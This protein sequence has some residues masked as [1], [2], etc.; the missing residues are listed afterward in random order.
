[1]PT[2]I[3]VYDHS[4]LILANFQ[5]TLELAGF[6]VTARFPREIEPPQVAKHQPDFILL[7]LVQE[8]Y[9]SS[10]ERILAIHDEPTLVHIPIVLAV[11]DDQ[12]IPV[13]QDV[14]GMVAVRYRQK[15][16]N[17]DAAIAAIRALE[18]KDSSQ[19]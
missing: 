13:P 15:P 5:H 17:I 12:D 18:N 11:P 19:S 14:E 1:M 10:V 2:H 8:S 16:F 3:L 9:R 4:A 7:A 6:R